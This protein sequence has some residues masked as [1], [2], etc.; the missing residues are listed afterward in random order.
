MRDVAIVAFAQTDHLRRTDEL[1]E[2]DMLMPVLHQ[3]LDVTGLKASDIGFTCSGS[4]DYLMRPS[5]LL[6]HG[7]RR[8][9]RPPADLRVPCG[10]GRRLGAVRGMGET[11]DGRGRH[12]SRLR[13]REVLSRRSARRPHPPAR[14]VLRR[15]ALAR[16]RRPRRT[17]GPGADRR[18]PHRRGRPRRDCRPQPHRCRGQPARTALGFGPGR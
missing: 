8:R 9:R 15:P 12:R 18:G 2:V 17:P 16:L 5:L 10:D 4:S 1:S 11:P 3:V 13:V 6:H 14:P 7:A